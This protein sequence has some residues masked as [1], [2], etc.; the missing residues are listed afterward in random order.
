MYVFYILFLIGALVLVGQIIAVQF[1]FK[2][3]PVIEGKLTP[4]VTKDVM[5]PAR[6]AILARDGRML[7]ISFPSYSIAM[8]PSVL[9]TSSPATP[10]KARSG[11]GSGS[12]RPGTCPQAWRSSSP[13]R[14]PPNIMR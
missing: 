6:G 4:P 7:A 5:R 1:F 2:P 14:P 8:D 9:R 10:R 3:D 11:R 12:T 13:R